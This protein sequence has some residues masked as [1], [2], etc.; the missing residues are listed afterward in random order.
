MNIMRLRKSSQHKKTLFRTRTS[1]PQRP[2]FNH[3]IMVH[4]KKR[5]WSPGAPSGK[6]LLVRIVENNKIY[7][8]FRV[9]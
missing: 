2:F 5:I 6:M 9:G 1:K 8:Y 7:A 4:L 3:M